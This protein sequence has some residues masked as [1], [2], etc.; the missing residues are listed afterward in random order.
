M[1]E[2]TIYPCIRLGEGDLNERA[3]VCGDPARA[4]EISKL[5]D[6]PVCLNRN[7]EYFS[8]SGKWKGVPISVVSHGVG[9]A[10]ASF[11]FE[12]MMKIGVK[13]IIRVGT[14]GGMQDGID[15]GK[16]V[17]ATASCRDDGVTDRMLPPGYPAICNDEVI[18][19]LQKSAQQ[20]KVEYEKGL[21]LTTAL[22]YPSLM[23]SSVKLYAKAGVKALENEVSGL[24]VLAGIYGVKAGAI[25]AADAKA[26]ELHDPADY[27]PSQD[28][29]VNAIETQIKIALDAL[30][31]IEV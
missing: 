18:H 12:S 8:F 6:D 15:A 11:A 27:R 13:V 2:R 5:L 22:L 1:S 26:F 29:V 30:V 10:G 9:C 7:R 31:D 17:I 16:I 24:L 21:I 19:A 14:C 28:V 4:E 3:L 23:G 25:L 20:N